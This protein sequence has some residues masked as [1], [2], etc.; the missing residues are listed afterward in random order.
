MSFGAAKLRAGPMNGRREGEAMVRIVIRAIGVTFVTVSAL[1][2]IVDAGR[3][4]REPPG[5]GDAPAL[6]DLRPGPDILADVQPSAEAT[7]PVPGAE[8]A[9]PRDDGPASP[10]EALRALLAKVGSGEEAT[11]G[12]AVPED[13]AVHS[14]VPSGRSAVRVNHGLR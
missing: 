5:L 6:S 4:S 1:S 14:G 7:V 3:S 9:A 10:I 8:F 12:A 13:I 11:G 2:F